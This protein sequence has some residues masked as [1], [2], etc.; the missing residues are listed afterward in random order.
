M[1]TKIGSDEF[2]VFILVYIPLAAFFKQDS[3]RELSYRK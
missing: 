3:S 1:I 2:F